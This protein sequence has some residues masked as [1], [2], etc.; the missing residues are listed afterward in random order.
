MAKASSGSWFELG[1]PSLAELTATLEDVADLAMDRTVRLA[2]TG[3]RQSGK[4]VFIT[5]LV[6]HLLAGRE[7][8]F[9]NAARDGRLLGARLLERRPGDLPR[10]PFEPAQ[11]ALTGES[12][13]WPP[14]TRDLAGLR[15]A[16]RYRIEGV[17]R[18]QLGEHRTIVVEIIDYPGEWLLDLPL[19]E[20]DYPTWSA[21]VLAR[22]RKPPR[23]RLAAPWLGFVDTLDPMGPP[24]PE[25]A[26]TAV[27]LHRQY[28]QA[29]QAAGLSLLQPGRATID[30]PLLEDERL[31]FCPLPYGGDDPR[32]LA[33]LM[34]GR[35]ERYKS[36]IVLPFYRDHFSRFD[37]QIIL[38]DVLAL[39]NRGR[40][41][42]EDAQ[43]ALQAIL[44]SFRYGQSSLLA[45]LF[46]PRIERLLFAV[47]KADHVAHNQHPNLRQLLEHMVQSSA[48]D[49]RFEGI[50]PAFVA[51]ASVRSTE[52][53]RTEHHGQ[54][55]SCV[56]GVPKGG[57][58]ETILFPGEIP[59]DLPV[60]ED[61]DSGRFRFRDFAPRRLRLEAERPQHIRLDQAL[62]VLL[63]DK[64]R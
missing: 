48:G 59:P 8:P 4:T 44:K 11:A 57:G 49:A 54:M 61:W 1:L 51:L 47:T 26:A 9:L 41:V 34:A 2:V 14:P 19:L 62:D 30:G 32:T 22:A 46:N 33:G 7:L 56:R 28:K 3:L 36:T 58:G 35:Y 64:L 15:L 5:A 18:R 21:D 31:Q 27:R 42:F 39:L 17:L 43:R 37:R 38:V 55:L 25:V 53:V 6:H 16:L 50:Q 63:G 52:V 24:D 20:L 12:P 60:D 13:H 29:A 10:F 40:H 23:D 45:R